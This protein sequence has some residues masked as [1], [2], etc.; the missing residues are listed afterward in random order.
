MDG[1]AERPDRL[2]YIPNSVGIINCAEYW[3]PC[4]PGRY[5]RDLLSII[6]ENEFLSRCDFAQLHRLARFMIINVF[7]A[8]IFIMPSLQWGA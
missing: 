6:K 2:Q 7:V 8:N 1:Q 3:L 5:K 4:S